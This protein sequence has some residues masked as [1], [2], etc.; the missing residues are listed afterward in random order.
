M[1]RL[2]PS[3]QSV[4]T[5][6]ASTLVATGSTL[7]WLR[8]DPAHDGPVISIWLPGMDAGLDLWGLVLVP[9]V[10]ALGVL[11]GFSSRQISDLATLAVGGLSVG[12][13][14]L[15]WQSVVGGHFVPDVGWYVALVGSLLLLTVGVQRVGSQF[16]GP[17]AEVPA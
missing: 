4:I 15:Y 10:L 5:L 17:Q 9:A 12:L 2:S 7:P 6:V 1:R 16:D 13:V 8:A 11:H 14:A 3:T